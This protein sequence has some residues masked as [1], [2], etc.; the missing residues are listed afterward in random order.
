MSD[1][2]FAT[3]T[4]F[5][6]GTMGSGIAQ[7]CAQAGSE[8]RLYDVNQEVL[9]R[10]VGRLSAFLAKGVA[11]GK[12]TADVSAAVSARVTPTTDFG[13]AVTGANLVIEA[14]P[15]IVELKNSTFKRTS[16]LVGTGTVLATNTSS[17]SLAKIFSGIVG[18]GRCIGMH[19]FNPPP[20][21]PLLEIVRP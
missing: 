1:P 5:G 6:A 13:A 9:D 15:E 8:V 21:M 2:V 7:I 11:R 19:F 20:L 10:G 12:M 4:V 17:L 3:V 14:I 16:E 18:P